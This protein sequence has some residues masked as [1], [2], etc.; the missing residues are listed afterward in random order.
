MKVDIKKQGSTSSES[1]FP[2]TDSYD[3]YAGTTHNFNFLWQTSQNTQPGYY[4]ITMTSSVPDPK[5]DQ[6]NA[7]AN[8]QTKTVYI[9][10]SLDTCIASLNNFQVTSTDF[11]VNHAVDFSGEHL[12]VYQNWSY[13]SISSCQAEDATLTDGKIFTT[14]YTLTIRN[15]S[16][17]EVIDVKTGK[18]PKNTDYDTPRAFTISWTPQQY[19]SYEAELET[20]SKSISL[21][22]PLFCAKIC[23]I[24]YTQSIARHHHHATIPGHPDRS[25]LL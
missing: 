19:G 24:M 6:T 21:P 25:G 4:E 8:T 15:R 11:Q 3:I 10:P 18:L 2:Q 14:S 17:N 20:Q 12:N 23:P 9:A 22:E 13:D 16:N 1:G 7:V 5:C